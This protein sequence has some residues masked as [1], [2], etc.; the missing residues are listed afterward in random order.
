M[1]QNKRNISIQLIRV[2]ATFMIVTD[3]MFHYCNF[4][5]KSLIIQVANSGVFIFLFISGLLF[6]EKEITNW[7]QW[8]LKRGTRILIP[9]WFFIIVDFIVEEILRSDVTIKQILAYAFN[10]Q[11]L[12][13]IRPTT[14]HLWFLTLLMICYLITPVLYKLKRMAWTTKT[15]VVLIVAFITAQ[16]LCSYCLSFGLVF[17]HTVGWCLL[18]IG[19]YSLAFFIGD[20]ILKK[21]TNAKGVIITT[22]V[23]VVV[24]CFCLLANK[25]ID[26]TKTYDVISWYGYVLVDFWIITI[27]YAIGKTQIVSSCEKIIYFLDQI[28][29][30]FYLVH[31]FMLML[32]LHYLLQYINM[33]VYILLAIVLSIIG[34]III[35]HITQPAIKIVNKKVI[36]E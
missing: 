14:N 9:F 2:V 20:A 25:Y 1:E 10:L 23:A 26:T 19:F 27:L 5:I 29:Y 35:N 6:G 36:K 34:A 32:L 21:S 16:L 22:I 15:K 24:S 3:H 18:A 31:N 7:K 12:F 28:S 13:G 30:E 8:F 11:G 17:G 4:P 33:P